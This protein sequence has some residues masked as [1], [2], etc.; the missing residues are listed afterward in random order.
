MPY[1]PPEVVAR[2]CEMDLLTYLRTYEPQ[3]LVHFGGSTHCTHEYDGLKVPKNKWFWFS[4][5]IGCHSVLDYLANQNIHRPVLA[6]FA[7]QPHSD[8][9][10]ERLQNVC[11]LPMS[12]S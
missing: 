3:E 9:Q 4:H 1:I 5:G 6:G 12:R 11:V 7:A 10:L 2:A 8:V